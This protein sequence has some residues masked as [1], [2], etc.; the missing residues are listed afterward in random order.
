MGLA[1]SSNY[2]GQGLPYTLHSAVAEYLISSNWS[3]AMYPG[4]TQGAIA[5]IQVHGSET[6]KTKPGCRK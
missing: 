2:G 3:F 4:L 5:A 6:T 1:A